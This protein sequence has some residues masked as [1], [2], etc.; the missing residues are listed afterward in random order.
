[1]GMLNFEVVVLDTEALL[2]TIVGLNG[3]DRI[4][5]IRGGGDVGEGLDR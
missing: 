1:V 3:V 4:A 5:A 2:T